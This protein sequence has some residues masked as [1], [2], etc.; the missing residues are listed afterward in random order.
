MTYNIGEIVLSKYRV[1][2]W[3]G[4]GTYTRVLRVIHI[5]T[6]EARTLKVVREGSAGLD[7]QRM[8]W[9]KARFQL[10]S[11]LAEQINSIGSHPNLLEV[12]GYHEL[13]GLPVLERQYASGGSLA[14]LLRTAHA[15]GKPIRIVKTLKIAMETADGLSALHMRNIVHRDLKP[16]NILFDAAHNVR[17]SDL[18]LAQIPPDLGL[19]APGGAP[20]QFLNNTAYLSPEQTQARQ[21]LTPPSDV[22]ALGAILFE[23]LTGVG[24]ITVEPGTS[25]RAV[26]PNIPDWLGDLVDRML[27]HEPEKRPWGGAVVSALLRAGLYRMIGEGENSAGAWDEGVEFRKLARAA[28]QGEQ[29]TSQ[30]QTVAPDLSVSIPNPNVERHEEQIHGWGMFWGILK[31]LLQNPVFVIALIVIVLVFLLLLAL[32]LRK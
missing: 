4:G 10:E 6:Q 13:D 2:E 8:S 5:H 14:D 31:K 23:M 28:R 18:Y 26:R 20:T 30:P 25:L 21:K 3:L 7:S 27:S 15:A 16:S 11:N 19:V 1:D 24:Y 22:Y 29:E 17:V 9:L 12:C 32:F